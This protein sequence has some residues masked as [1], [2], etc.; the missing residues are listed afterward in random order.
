MGIVLMHGIPRY[1][2]V[3]GPA[4]FRQGFKPFFLGAGV[5]AVVALLIWL[6]VIRGDV[7]L[8]TIFAPARWHAHE[9]LFGFAVAAVAGFMLTAIPNWTGRMPLQGMPLMVLFGAWLLGRVAMATSALMGG[10]LGAIVDLSFLAALFGVVLREVLAGRNW[11]NLPMPAAVA[12]LVIAN[13]LTQLEANH[14]LQ[15]GMLGERLGLAMIVLLISLIGGRII[16][17]FTRNWLAKRGAD[18]MP[19]PFGRFDVAALILV[20]AALSLWVASPNSPVAGAALIAA[21][22][23]SFARLTRWRGVRTG[24]EPL[25]WVL[26]LG[27]AWVAAGLCLLGAGL[28]L[29]ASVPYSA[30]LHALSAG[31]IGTMILAVMTRATRGHTGRALTA[32]WSTAAIYSLITLAAIVRVAA[33]FI[34]AFYLP[35]LMAS[36]ALWVATFSLFVACYGP[37]LWTA[38]D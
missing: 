5:W 18:A 27:Y 4:L 13:G 6:A 17:S 3:E 36:G 2:T 14:L 35:L 31:A 34:P 15:S 10:P 9:M 32:G 33:P 21:G 37:M 23:I 25:L 29:P 11:R 26:H 12:V 1:R 16:P 8:P 20:L 30:G 19:V 22:L 28:L 7:S 38:S 24:A